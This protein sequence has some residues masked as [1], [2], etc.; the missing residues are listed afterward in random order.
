[1][2]VEMMSWNLRVFSISLTTRAGLMSVATKVVT[3]QTRMPAAE[4]MR[5]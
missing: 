4:I 1:M 5:G 3:K 2:T